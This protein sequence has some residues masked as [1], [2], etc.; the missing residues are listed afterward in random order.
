MV[1]AGGT[2]PTSSLEPQLPQ[3]RLSVGTSAPQCGQFF[4]GMFTFRGTAGRD[5][6]FSTVAA[7]SQGEAAALSA[8]QRA[9]R[10]AARTIA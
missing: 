3:K 7:S 5:M 10:A 2:P 4:P 9:A 8:L 1:F 6:A